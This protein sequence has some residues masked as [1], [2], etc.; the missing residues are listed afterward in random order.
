MH[1]YATVFTRAPL[2]PTAKDV[3]CCINA[4]SATSPL[5]IKPK[6]FAHSCVTSFAHCCFANVHRG[7]AWQMERVCKSKP[8][9]RAPH[10]GLF[11]APLV[12]VDV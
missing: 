3:H 2:L 10:D 7:K 5:R 4:A 8:L 11:S 6:Q 1:R 9:P 12:F